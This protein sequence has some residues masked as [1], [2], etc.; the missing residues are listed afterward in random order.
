MKKKH[1][2]LKKYIK[3][4]VAVFIDAANILYSQQTLGWQIDYKKIARYFQKNSTLV[5]LGFYYGTIKENQGQARFFSMLAD[6]G[7]TV[8]TKP[9][10]YIKTVK[11]TIL[12]GNLDIELALDMMQL[13]EKYNIVVLFSG[14]SDFAAVVELVKQK[15]KKVIVISSRGHI[16]RELARASDKYIPLETLRSSFERNI[17]KSPRR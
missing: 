13:V 10:K 1:F 8:R 17:K 4:N 12:K 7:F 6:R 9:V 14:D 2:D 11:G 3:A 5:F 15:G 16:A